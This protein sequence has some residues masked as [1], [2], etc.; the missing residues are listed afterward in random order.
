MV[1]CRASSGYDRA[2]VWCIAEPVV[3]TE[4]END[5][6]DDDADSHQMVM[7]WTL[8]DWKVGKVQNESE[9]S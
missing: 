9:Q 1:H 5:D 6:D 2:T 7:S 8:D 4:S 3:G